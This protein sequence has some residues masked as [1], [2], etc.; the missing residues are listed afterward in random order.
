MLFI[1]SGLIDLFELRKEKQIFTLN[2][3]L[4]LIQI[5]FENSL[6]RRPKLFAIL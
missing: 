4:K 1:S 3:K 2:L 6:L 5:F